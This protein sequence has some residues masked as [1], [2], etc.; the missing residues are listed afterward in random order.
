M[1]TKKM[2][3]KKRAAHTGRKGVKGQRGRECTGGETSGG[4]IM[5]AV[6][7]GA[8]FNSTFMVP[9]RGRIFSLSFSLLHRRSL[10]L[11]SEPR[12]EDPKQ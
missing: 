3:M 10:E 4:A 8:D 12:P 9:W 1:K 7:K 11:S 6:E 5:E 2:M